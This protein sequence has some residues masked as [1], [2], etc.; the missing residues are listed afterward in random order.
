MNNSALFAVSDR[1]ADED[2]LELDRLVD[3]HNLERSGIE[4]ARLMS[5]MVRSS[6]GNLLAGLH[7]Y[8]WGGYCEVKSLWVAAQL[9]G[10]GVGGM[11]LR[12]AENEASERG[13][14]LVLLTTH[15][16]QAAGFYRIHGYGEV[17]AV[18]DC[19]RGHSYILM[20]KALD[21]RGPRQKPGPS[22]M[23]ID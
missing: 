9:R 3:S 6:G 19:P 17:A 13:C 10:Q 11:L 5:I 15:S 22:S 1:L 12:S 14:R 7:G 4:D 16:F 8:T 21:C 23:R 20:S 18:D 2:Q